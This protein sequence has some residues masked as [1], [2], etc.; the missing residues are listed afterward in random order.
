MH[1]VIAIFVLAV[2]VVVQRR[3]KHNRDIPGPLIGSITSY[4]RVWLLIRGVAPTEYA[5]LHR[6]YGKVVKT[7][8]NHVSIADVW[9]IPIVYDSKH[10]FIKVTAAYPLT[11]RT[12]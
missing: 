10:K 11:D 4:Y 7:G 6:K 2:C 12:C 1:L 3:L 5:S 9:C 8:P